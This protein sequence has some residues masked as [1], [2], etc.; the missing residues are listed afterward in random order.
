MSYREWW[1]GDGED[2][3]DVGTRE[4]VCPK[5]GSEG[6]LAGVVSVTSVLFAGAWWT[7]VAV[8]GARTSRLGELSWAGVMTGRPGEPPSTKRYTIS[9]KSTFREIMK[10]TCD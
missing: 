8:V 1:E 2:T 4:G 3:L 6:E 9:W 5:L 7:D 10:F